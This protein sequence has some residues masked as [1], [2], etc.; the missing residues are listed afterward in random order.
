[1]RDLLKDCLFIFLS[2]GALSLILWPLA[3]RAVCYEQERERRL[4]APY[5]DKVPLPKG[6]TR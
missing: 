1:M 5:V 3:Y 6:V 4:C 2:V